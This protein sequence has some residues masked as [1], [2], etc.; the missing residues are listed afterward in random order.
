[1]AGDPGAADGSGVTLARHLARR[2]EA[3]GPISLAAFMGEALGHPRFGYYVTRDPLGET[4]DFTTAPEISQMF[5]ELLGLWCAD[6][7]LRMGS[8]GSV[9]L[10]ELGPGRGTL[11]ADALRAIG[12]A[13]PDFRRVLTVH[14]V[15]TSPVL[16][17]RQRAA[18]GDEPSWH[19]RL[20]DV[21]DGPALLLA[22]EFFDALPIHQFQRTAEGW[23][24]RLVALDNAAGD[25]PCFRLV[26]GPPMPL[27]G[28]APIG[29][30]IERSPA[31]L[32]VAAAIAGRLARS[33]GV[34]LI[35]DY[36]YAGPATGDTLQAVRRHA[37][38]PVLEAPG[39]ADLTAHVDFTALAGAARGVEAY[40]PVDQG[41]FLNALG[42]RERTAVLAR[43]PDQ[44]EAVDAALHRLTA[45]EAMGTLFKALALTGPG[46]GPPAGFDPPRPDAA[47]G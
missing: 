25:E 15:E 40:G 35:V 47:G 10:I 9:R 6:A 27:E 8:P 14:L 26:L 29:T 17:Q 31:G 19:D 16:R 33:G 46:F 5:G 2:I 24:E 20:E 11:M 44:A 30:V 21:P 38:A 41:A 28:E 37:F 4:G 18:L 45:P 32:A 43:R 39:E 36:G 3:E 34:A 13:M 22:N 23:A 1:V 42:I 12:R 7:W